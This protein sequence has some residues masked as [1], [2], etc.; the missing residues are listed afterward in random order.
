MLRTYL[1]SDIRLPPLLLQIVESLVPKINGDNH[2]I[3]MNKKH[4]FMYN[5]EILGYRFNDSHLITNVS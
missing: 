4:I 2:P 5:T 1:G 3:H